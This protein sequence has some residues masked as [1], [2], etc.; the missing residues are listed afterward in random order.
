[1]VFG[2]SEPEGEALFQIYRSAFLMLR[3]PPSY[4]YLKDFAGVEIVEIVVFVD[5]LLSI[6]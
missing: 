6:R 3:N 1:L 2:E 5:F 4:R